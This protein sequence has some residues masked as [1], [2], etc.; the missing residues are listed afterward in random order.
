MW[1][2][3]NINIF[4]NILKKLYFVLWAMFSGKTLPFGTI[5]SS[6]SILSSSQVSK[7][8]FEI[9]LPLPCPGYTSLAIALMTTRISDS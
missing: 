4:E 5:Y 9:N 1:V 8:Y 2:A 7:L 3:K 6:I